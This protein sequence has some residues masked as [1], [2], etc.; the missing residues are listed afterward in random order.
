MNKIHIKKGKEKILRLHHPWV[1]SGAVFKTDGNP[2]NGE[3]VKVLDYNSDFIGYGY[4]NN[5]SQM[6]VRLL[7]WDESVMINDDWWNNKV[8]QS[9][10]RR[11]SLLKSDKTT[12]FR[13]INAEAD[14]LPGLIVDK[15]GDYIVM[16]V[17][18]AGIE[19]IKD[20]LADKIYAILKP[21]G[22]YERSDADVRKI[23]GLSVRCGLLKGSE[24]PDLIE[25][26]ENGYLFKV[27]IKEGQKT[28]FFIDQRDNRQEAAAYAQGK[29]VL[30]CFCHTGGF[31]VYA[32]K[33]GAANV[34]VIDSS[35]NALDLVEEN[36]RINNLPCNEGS[37]ICGDVFLILRKLRDENK[38]FDMIILDPPKLAPSRSYLDKALRA[39]K[40]INLLAMKLLNPDGILVTFS[41]SGGVT[42]DA[43][44]QAVAWA[45]VDAER[46]IQIVKTLSHAQDHPI[47]MSFPESEYLKGLIC[48]V[49]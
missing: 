32:L 10:N 24:P 34:T 38:K 2:E 31:A 45:S 29:N 18:T 17:L 13:L 6:I 33:N 22:I 35:N 19:K 16:Q 25:I 5:N 8:T 1:F 41:C 37:I 7:E 12:A 23:E 40:D 46:E 9:I 20:S 21:E 44:K 39:Y 42:L 11:A 49:L 26:K 30:D 48:K 43:F 14:L 27:N 15:Y 3:I 28:G 47:R 36:Y 4:Y